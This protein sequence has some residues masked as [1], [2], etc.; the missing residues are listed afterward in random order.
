MSSS[1]GPSDETHAGRPRQIQS[2]IADLFARRCAGESL[3]DDQVLAAHPQLQPELGAELRKRSLIEA[4]RRRAHSDSSAFAEADDEVASP[5][6]ALPGRVVA[7]T[8]P[9][10]RIEAELHRGGQGVVCRAIQLSTGRTVAVKLLREG[11]LAAPVD[12]ARFQQEI[13]ILAQLRHP[14]IVTVH[15]SG[16]TAGC[17]YYVMDFVPGLPLDDWA[18]ENLPGRQPAEPRGRRQSIAIRRDFRIAIAPALRL[19]VKICDAVNVA[20]LRGVIHRDLKPGNI[21]VDPAGEPH[22]LD[23]GLAKLSAEDPAAHGASAALTQT[24]QFVGS[25]YW[26]SPE[27]ADGR[28][29]ELDVRTDVYS[30]GVMLYQVLTG[31]FPFDHRGSTREVLERI[32]KTDPIRPGLDD[33]LETILLKCLSKERERRYQSA[34][35]LAR[36]LER[37]LAGEAIEAKRDSAGYVL[38]KQLR[39]HRVAVGI[40]AGFVLLVSAALAVS[41]AQWR[42]TAAARDQAQLAEQQRGAERDAARRAELSERAQRERAER[43]ESL[44]KAETV[45][46]LAVKS[47]LQQVFSSVDPRQAQGREVTVRDALDQAARRLEQ[48]ALAEQGEIELDLRTTIGRTYRSLGLYDPAEEHLHRAADL[49]AALFGDGD[50]RTIRCQLDLAGLRGDQGRAAEAEIILR[51]ALNILR[52]SSGGDHELLATALVNLG[53]QLFFQE[54]FDEAESHLREAAD[55][56]RALQTEEPSNQAECL[57]RLG[58]VLRA[59]GRCSQAQRALRDALL[60][61]RRL[62]PA[63]HPNV[64]VA[65]NDL[66]N[67]LFECGDLNES[68]SLFQEALAMQRRLLEP[69]HP[70]L[71]MSLGNLAGVLQNADRLEEAETLMREALDMARRSLGDEHVLTAQLIFGLGDL[72]RIRGRVDLAEPLLQQA[73]DLRRKLLPAQHSDISNT[74]ATIALMLLDQKRPADAE[75]LLRECL[76]IRS[77]ANPPHWIRHSTATLLALC[78]AQLGKFEEAEA[79]ALDGH[80]RMEADESAPAAWKQTTLERVARIYELWNQQHPDAGKAPAAAAW[81]AKLLRDPATS[82]PAE[83]PAP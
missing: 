66:G 61:F 30:L 47:F 72:L 12:V 2:I 43:S 82:Q 40:A 69:G 1:S 35:E 57:E 6:P 77:A 49:S 78:L 60:I 9:G 17:A 7:E 32:V 79:L 10:Y 18:A 46:A 26:A 21:R 67:T 81:R 54:K 41:L 44:A 5:A 22:I 83:A 13:Q 39:R 59:Q 75:P 36:E 56:Y 65:L 27:Q 25:L 16:E 80:A 45:K 20:H 38:R 64:V 55:L 15:D 52:R 14:N 24:G 4:A 48:G 70:D 62:Y 68:V 8:I 19:F 63:P 23:F 3:T 11:P 29:D 33:E 34:G 58:N 50:E 76:A 42:Q 53:T 31:G 73:L 51:A 71:A 74:L 28:S 37:Y